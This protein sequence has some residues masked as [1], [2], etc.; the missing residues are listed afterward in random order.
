MDKKNI[1]PE[2][3]LRILNLRKRTGLSRAKLEAIAGVSASTLRYAETGKREVTTLQARLL[4]TIFIYR[5][6][7]EEEEASEGFLLHGEKNND[8]MK[9]SDKEIRSRKIQN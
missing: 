5:F 8:S 2:P 7:L 1:S 6:G 9:R 3:G 4:S